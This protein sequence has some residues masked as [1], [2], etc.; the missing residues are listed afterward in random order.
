MLD[1]SNQF[2]RQVG[3]R[4]PIICGA[5]YPCS[6]PEL[7]SAVSKAGGIGIVQ[8]VS[9]T[10]VYKQDFR[11]GIRQIIKNAGAPIGLNLLIEKSSQKYLE[12]NQKW[13][14]IALE[15]GVRFFISALGNPDWV[16]ERCHRAGAIVY[17]DVTSRQWAQ[18][19]L[20]ANVD[21]LICVNN[22]AG[23]HAGTNS[24][25]QLFEDLKS[26]GKPLICAGGIGSPQD[27]AEALKMGYLGVQMGTRFIATSECKAHIDYKNAIIKSD[28]ENIVL[29]RKL[30]GVPVSVIKTP[31]VESLGTEP[32][33]FMSMLLRGRKTKHYARMYYTL[34]SLTKLKRSLQKASSSRDY[35]QA[36]KSVA[37]IDKIE[38]A[39][40][41]IRH[42]EEY[43][44]SNAS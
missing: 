31:Y 32:G 21:G 22:R 40:D 7:V 17:H 33:W 28:A 8:P 37:G 42:F 6:N 43:I 12:M 5:M 4:M 35:Y 24:P 34:T 38:S 36:G 44:R 1:L 10:Y 13:L 11:E 19:A 14:E 26:A 29:T 27:F 39:G 2:T 15:E 25:Q 41:V 3:C 16:V 23:G 20:S 18:K 9:L 30:T